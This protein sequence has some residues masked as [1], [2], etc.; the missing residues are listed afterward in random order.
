MYFERT[1]FYGGIALCPL[2]HTFP[3][4]EAGEGTPPSEATT[5]GH[6]DSPRK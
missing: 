4:C 6:G 1:E 5:N 2:G 3:R